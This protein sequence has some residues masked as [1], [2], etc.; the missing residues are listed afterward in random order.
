MNASSGFSFNFAACG[1]RQITNRIVGGESALEGAWPW[2]VDVQI[3]FN[4]HVCGGSLISNK[5]VLSAAHC[6]PESSDKS[7]YVLYMGRYQLNGINNNLQSSRVKRVVVASG[8][9]D[10]QEG[11]DVALVELESPVTWTDYV[12]PICLPD[13]GLEFTGGT[14]CFVT[15]WGHIRE[16]APL[17]GAGTLQEVEVPIIDQAECRRMYQIPSN[18]ETVDILSDMLCAGFQDGGK[19]SCQGDSG[20]PLVCHTGNGTWVQAGIVS[21]GLGCAQPNRPGIYARVSSFS[22]FIQATVPEAQ[23]FAHAYGVKASGTLV[24]TFTLASVLMLR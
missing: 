3:D 17:V 10:P 19:D 14:P 7:S 5:W 20:G 6:F 4:G 24:L 9:V 2:Q 13:A 23:L 16:G 8:Y 1:K 21:F 18:S 11:N 15:G 12:Q 22:D